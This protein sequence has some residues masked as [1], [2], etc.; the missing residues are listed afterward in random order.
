MISPIPPPPTHALR[1]RGY[2]TS[3]TGGGIARC[4]AAAMVCGSG[5]GDPCYVLVAATGCI[6]KDR[7]YWRAQHRLCGGLL[8][9]LSAVALIGT[10]GS[11]VGILDNRQ[12][13]AGPVS[14]RPCRALS[15][16]R[17]RSGSILVTTR[18][19]RDEM[20]SFLGGGGR[21]GLVTTA[22]A[23]NWVETFDNGPTGGF[24]QVWTAHDWAARFWVGLCAGL[25]DQSR[26]GRPRQ[27]LL[28]RIW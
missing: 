20:Q 17:A 23:D 12:D 2:R 28:R 25:R 22:Y 14:L 6:G 8:T 9:V 18:E 26:D 24:D 5:S 15:T 1:E 21:L 16:G 19:K 10:R 27:Q 7:T 3:Q 4:S 11:W 13:H